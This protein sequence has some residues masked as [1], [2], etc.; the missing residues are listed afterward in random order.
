MGANL[1]QKNS[2]V[3]GLALCLDAG[4]ASSASIDNTNDLIMV[5]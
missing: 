1:G 4:N 2:I 5:R 3:E